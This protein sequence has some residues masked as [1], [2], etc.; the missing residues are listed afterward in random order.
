MAAAY[1]AAIGLR[2]SF[3]VG[4]SSSPPARHSAGST[5]K[6]LICSLRAYV[7]R[8]DLGVKTGRGLY[9]DYASGA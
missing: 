3:V 8:G 5:T 7:D 4:V 6:R 2:L 1:F 9:D